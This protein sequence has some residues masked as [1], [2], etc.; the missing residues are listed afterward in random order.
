MARNKRRVKE[1]HATAEPQKPVGV[2]LIVVA[3]PVFYAAALVYVMMFASNAHPCYG[4][5]WLFVDFVTY[6]GLSYSLIGML[7]TVS[8]LTFRKPFRYLAIAGWIFECVIYSMIAYAFG[9]N[10]VY[11]D[12]GSFTNYNRELLI[13]VAV[14]LAFKIASVAYFYTKKVK[15]AF[16]A[17][18]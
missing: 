8:L 10:T 13:T 5:G 2:F 6:V 12:S 14:I 9:Q 11:F 7:G 16:N 1:G 4:S 18:T 15:Q 17:Q 3:N